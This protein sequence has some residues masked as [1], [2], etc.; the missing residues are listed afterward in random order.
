M[1]D[2]A[3][4]G[5]LAEKCHHTVIWPRPSV[6]ASELNLDCDWTTLLGVTETLCRCSAL[7]AFDMGSLPKPAGTSK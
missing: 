4:S 2:V 5:L 7:C 1:L 3:E 6:Y